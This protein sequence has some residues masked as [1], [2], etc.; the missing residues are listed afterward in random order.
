M[1]QIITYQL[2][3]RGLTG[4]TFLENNDGSFSVKKFHEFQWNQILFNDNHSRNDIIKN[5]LN[6]LIDD[7][8][9]NT[10]LNDVDKFGTDADSFNIIKGI[11]YSRLVD[12]FEEREAFNKLV[13][14]NRY[15]LQQIYRDEDFIER[16]KIWFNNHNKI[17]TCQLC[18][19]KFKATMLPGSI[20][21]NSNGCLVCC[22][23]CKILESPPTE[24]IPQRAKEFVSACGFI[25]VSNYSPENFEFSIRV[26]S[27]KWT[28][29]LKAYARLGSPNHIKEKTGSWFKVLVLSGSLPDNILITKRGVRCL[30]TDGTECSSLSEQFITNWMITNKVEFQK[31]PFYPK[32]IKYNTSGR[33]RADW[34]I[35]NSY[36]EYFGLTGEN[37]YDKKTKEKIK[38][39][40]E[41]NFELI[42]IFPRDL[43]N[44]N[45]VLEKFK[46][47]S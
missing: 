23:T 12:K 42:S 13:S 21:K 6:Y 25:P 24:T 38:L 1:N 32:H 46:P 9:K 11:V 18:G 33:R 30:A 17:R 3:V 15:F 41:L 2:G 26:Q 39:A 37:D 28:D 8:I 40:N 20:L 29:V 47:D 43:R 27:D 5:N 36:I 22:F 10:Y 4:D 16:M 31:E 14:L 34:K 7:S 19:K 35:G 45:S 44:L